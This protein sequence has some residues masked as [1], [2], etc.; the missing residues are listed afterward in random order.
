VTRPPPSLF[1][2]FFLGERLFLAASY[3]C[4]F[5][6]SALVFAQP[7]RKSQQ[8]LLRTPRARLPPGRPSV[9]NQ[10]QKRFFDLENLFAPS[11]PSLLSLLLK[12]IHHNGG[13]QVILCSLGSLT[14][15]RPPLCSTVVLFFLNFFCPLSEEEETSFPS[16]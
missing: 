16:P 9:V 12:F 14:K 2:G 13:G 8:S 3:R 7:N 11:P 4:P 6:D 15:T 1:P 10:R 5:F